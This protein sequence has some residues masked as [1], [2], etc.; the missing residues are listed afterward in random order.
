MES[1]KSQLE[2]FKEAAREAECDTDETAF[3]EA[4][5]KVAKSKPEKSSTGEDDQT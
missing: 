4:L 2:K 5:K 1:D 3:E